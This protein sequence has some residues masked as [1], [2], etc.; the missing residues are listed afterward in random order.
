[1]DKK[2]EDIAWDLFVKTGE[3]GYYMLYKSIIKD[4]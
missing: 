2:V 4:E 1:M 3:M